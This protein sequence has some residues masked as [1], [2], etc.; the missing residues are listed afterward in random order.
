MAESA[1][2]QVGG[3]PSLLERGNLQLQC[4]DGVIKVREAEAVGN[5]CLLSWLLFDSMGM[6]RCSSLFPMRVVCGMPCRC[7]GM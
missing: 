3:L 1:C 2:A 4:S 5:G 7:Q 6:F